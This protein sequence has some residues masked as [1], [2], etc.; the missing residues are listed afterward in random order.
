MKSVKKFLGLGAVVSANLAMQFAFQWYIIISFGAGPQTDVFFGA[1]AVPQFILLVLSS[2]L[3][4]VLIPMLSNKKDHALQTEGWNYFQA[5]GLLFGALALLL[6]VTAHWWVQWVLPGFKTTNFELAVHLSRIQLLSMIF[7]A[8][9]SVLWSIHSVKQNFYLIE[10]TSILANL[11]SLGLL[12]LAVHYKNLYAATWISVLRTAL[13][14]VFLMRVLG[15]RQ[16]L[17]VQS[18]SFTEA[19][20]KLRTLIAGNIYFKTDTLIDRH[21]TSAGSGGDLTLLNL[22]QQLYSMASTILAKTFIN[23]LIPSL[24]VKAVNQKA[25]MH[26]VFRKRLWLLFIISVFLFALIILLG[27]PLLGFLFGLK[28]FDAAAVNRLWLLLVLLFGFW[29]GGLL[30]MLTS[31]TFYAKGDT[32]TPTRMTVILFSLY[33]P[34]KVFIFKRF[35][36]EGLALSISAYML[37]SLF[38]QL[39]LLERKKIYEPI[40]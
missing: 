31:G 12:L 16:K 33:L 29:F 37:V 21:L 4:M 23:T 1:Q 32:K 25:E 13:Q 28:N 35:G 19:W 18:P 40:T 34:I 2:S 38:L 39:F 24:S 26:L 30:G 22:A 11:I 10:T 17:I 14:V 36:I 7:S 15:P 9:L 5:I 8:L 20:R 6:F 27:K 3:T